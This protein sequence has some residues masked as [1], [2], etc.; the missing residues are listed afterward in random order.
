MLNDIAADQLLIVLAGLLALALGTR[1]CSQIWN[2][3]IELEV[4][5]KI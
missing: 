4:S 1:K 5:S 3:E 2:K